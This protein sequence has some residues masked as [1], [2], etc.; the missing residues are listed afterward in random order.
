V[1]YRRIFDVCFGVHALVAEDGDWTVDDRPLRFG[2]FVSRREHT[3]F[4]S[5][6]IGPLRL[7]VAIERRENRE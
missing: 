7:G 6:I 3:T 5:F 4:Y 2:P 1:S